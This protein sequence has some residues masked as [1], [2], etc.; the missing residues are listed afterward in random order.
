MPQRLSELLQAH[1]IAQAV[2]AEPTMSKRQVLRRK[3]APTQAPLLQK[4]VPG[5]RLHPLSASMS[6]A[7]P[8]H[9][10]LTISLLPVH[11]ATTGNREG[12]RRCYGASSSFVAA[13]TRPSNESSNGTDFGIAVSYLNLSAV[14]LG[15]Y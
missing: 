8:T 1:E 13:A 14:A 3:V 4:C 10:F 11:F 15:L 7:D 12:A 2:S 5:L 9:Q 6:V